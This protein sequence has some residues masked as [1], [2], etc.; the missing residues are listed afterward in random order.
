LGGELIGVNSNTLQKGSG[1]KLKKKLK[2][3]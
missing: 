2:S 1:K 3:V